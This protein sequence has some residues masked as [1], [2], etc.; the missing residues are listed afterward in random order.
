MG[1]AETIS[2]LLANCEYSEQV[3][4]NLLKNIFLTVKILEEC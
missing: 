3:K 2:L 1:L 4:Q